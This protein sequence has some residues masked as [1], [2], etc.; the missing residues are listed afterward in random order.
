[1]KE[2]LRHL[3][4]SLGT[5][6]ALHLLAGG[7]AGAV[8]PTHPGPSAETL[9]AAA[10]GDSGARL[11]LA[12][13]RAPASRP[14]EPVGHFRGGRSS[15]EA[16]IEFICLPLDDPLWGPGTLQSPRR[17]PFTADRLQHASLTFSSGLALGLLTEEPAA[18]A[19][20]A[21]VLGLVKELLDPRFD[22]GDFAADLVGA[23]LAALVTHALVR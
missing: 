9:R 10:A 12:P 17:G 21:M 16:Q 19:G 5:L 3:R 14:V 7:V 23:A 6:V 4:T 2:T 11:D 1:M 18:A 22:R 15:G 20:G 8:P 13:R